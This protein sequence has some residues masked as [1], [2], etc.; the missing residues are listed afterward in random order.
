MQMTLLNMHPT[1]PLQFYNIL[2][3]LI[4]IEINAFTGCKTQAMAIGPVPYEYCYNFSVDNDAV[5]NTY[6]LKILGAALDCKLNF[7]AHVSKQV[8]K[9]CAKASVLSRIPRFIPL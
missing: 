2:S 4:F 6:T 3:T 1:F 8:K 5:D 9:A 7:V